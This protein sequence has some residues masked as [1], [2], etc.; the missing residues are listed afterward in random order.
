MDFSF[1]QEKV[2]TG[3]NQTYIDWILSGAGYTV[4]VSLS[5]FILALVL[6]ITVGALRT[7][8]GINAKLAHAFFEGVRSVPF[9]ALL[10]INIYVLPVL[11]APSW[12]KTADPTSV[13]LTVG[14][15]SL[16]IFMS[17]RIAAQVT[18][19]IKAL[20]EGQALAAKALGFSQAQAYTRFLIPQAMKNIIPSLT[21]EGMNTVKNSAVI[22]AIGLMDLT[23]QA[24]TII[25]YTAKPFEAFTCIVL[26][27]LLINWTVLLLMK[28]IERRLARN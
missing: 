18:A 25:D 21:S 8:T 3:E 9:I 17:T 20:P 14:I 7:T 2:A 6:G 4:A 22:S 26:G 15:F 10:F 12:I 11:L 5:A 1:L 16:G 13:I 19:G 23:K 28:L 24:Q 27:Y